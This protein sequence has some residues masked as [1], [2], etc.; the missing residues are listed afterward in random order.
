MFSDQRITEIMIVTP[1]V[2]LSPPSPPLP[3]PPSLPPLSTT[4]AE[5][6]PR[7]PHLPDAA[8]ERAGDGLAPEDELPRP[9]PDA[10]AQ[11]PR[12]W[13]PPAG[14]EPR[15]RTGALKAGSREWGRGRTGKAGTEKGACG[16]PTTTSWPGR[17]RQRPR[18]HG[19]GGAG[20]APSGRSA[21]TRGAG[22]DGGR[23]APPALR[24]GIGDSRERGDGRSW[25]CAW[26]VR[27]G[28]CE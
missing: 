20:R 16:T 23:R 11:R 7:G 27:R 5:T 3:P 6:A 15:R 26:V 14:H 1:S 10:P 12:R 18:S 19:G 2:Q 13:G 21:A 22:Q 17:R 24:G 4:L 9:P 8:D 25:D 28:V